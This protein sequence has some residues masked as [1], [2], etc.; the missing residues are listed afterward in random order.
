[1]SLCVLLASLVFAT[2]PPAFANESGDEAVVARSD[3]APEPALDAA[4]DLSAL[5]DLERQ[6]NWELTVDV[7]RMLDAI[8]ADRV[9]QQVRWLAEHYF[10]GAAAGGRV[11]PGASPV[12]LVSP[13]NS[14]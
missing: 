14:R 6:M 12:S 7:S 4:P 13:A 10:D 5:E 1:M 2:A 9:A 3:L 11:S 8:V